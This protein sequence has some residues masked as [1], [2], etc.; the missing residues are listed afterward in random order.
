MKIK[1]ELQFLRYLRYERGVLGC[2]EVSSYHNIADVLAIDKH[3]E[4]ILEY[5]F[6]RT[7]QDLKYAEKKKSK[8]Q[9]QYEVITKGNKNFYLS[10]RERPQPHKFYFVV[11]RELWEKEKV[12]LQA[13]KCGVIMFWE[14][15]FSEKLEFLVMKPCRLRKKNVQKFHVVVKDILARC[16]S[17]YVTQIAAI[18]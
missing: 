6:K 8:Y 9:P 16:T 11:P 5:E 7:S 2:N 1:A 3:K 4:H 13:Q 17:A 15:K 18:K 10:G 14:N 12:Y